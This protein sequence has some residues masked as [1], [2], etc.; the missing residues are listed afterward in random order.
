MK[1]NAIKK[2]NKVGHV[3]AILSKIIKVFLVIG[4]VGA[5]I[6]EVALFVLPKDL[7]NVTINGSIVLTIDGTSL[8]KFGRGASAEDWQREVEKFAASGSLEINDDDYSFSGLNYENG[9][10]ILE[11]NANDVTKIN[12]V[13]IRAAVALAIVLIA[14]TYVLMTF[15][16]RL[17]KEIELCSTPFSTEVINALTRFSYALLAY[18]LAGGIM[19]SIIS[20][21]VGNVDTSISINLNLTTALIALAV[22]ALTVVFKYGAILQQE[23]DET[24]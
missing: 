1:E 6:G 19:G 18:V 17:C 8:A 12:I 5:I 15:V 24:L 20:A 2:I 21:L 9:K 23:S 7:F 4:F 14:C 16:N 13:K 22:Y 10:Y 3:G 11:G